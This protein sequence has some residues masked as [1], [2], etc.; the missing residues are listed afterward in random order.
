MQSILAAL[1][2]WCRPHLLQGEWRLKQQSASLVLQD[3][4]EQDVITAPALRQEFAYYNC[5]LPCTLT[6][7]CS[8]CLQ[9][10]Y[11]CLAMFIQVSPPACPRRTCL[12]M[13]IQGFQNKI[14]NR[15][16]AVVGAGAERVE[17]SQPDH[18]WVSSLCMASMCCLVMFSVTDHW[19]G[20]VGGGGGG[21]CRRRGVVP[22]FAL[23]PG[24]RLPCGRAP[25]QVCAPPLA[26]LECTLHMC[27]QSG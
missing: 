25:G 13:C 6:S 11:H 2:D 23:P 27:D 1:A 18:F 26:Y 24:H 16:V 17:L 4:L 10:Q 5:T 20:M 12:V 9:L 14:G 21:R 3:H 15:Q 7:R 8:A 22:G 19:P